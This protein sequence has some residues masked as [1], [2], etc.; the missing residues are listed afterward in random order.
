MRKAKEVPELLTALKSETLLLSNA[1]R[2]AP[3]INQTNQKFW[4]TQASAYSNRELE[5]VIKT[6]FPE[7]EKRETI[8]TVSETKVSIT[9]E[10]THEELEILKKSQDL[11]AKKAKENIS[12]AKAI[13]GSAKTYIERH[14]PV[15]KAKRSK[16]LVTLPGQPSK[17]IPARYL[18]CVHKR[19]QGRCT[20]IY[21]D[22]KRCTH[23]R[24]IE[25]HHILPRSTGGTHESANLTTLCSG[26][27]QG[28]HQK[29]KEAISLHVG[30]L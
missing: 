30:T 9:I 25:L 15:E 18:H 16:G 10:V 24:F 6:H 2:I 23:T 26:H 3:I 1:R 5:K 4:I 17:T 20:Y 8:R 28:V 22:G 14:D 11:Q 19:D 13:V 7:T 27:H 12:M 29:P 21:P